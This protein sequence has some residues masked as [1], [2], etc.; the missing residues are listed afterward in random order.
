MADKIIALSFSVAQQ[1]EVERISVDNDKD[2]ALEFV[3]KLCEEFK[4]RESAH[5]KPIFDWTPEK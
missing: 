2:A 5:C 4:K 1:L 3:N